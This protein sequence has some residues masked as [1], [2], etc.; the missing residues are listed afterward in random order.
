MQRTLTIVGFILLFII[1]VVVLSSGVAAGSGSYNI[2]SDPLMAVVLIG[3]LVTVLILTVIV[4]IGLAQGF[5]AL[6]KQVAAPGDPEERPAIERAA[7]TT[8]DNV[9]GRL[10]GALKRVG[11]GDSEPV[12]PYVPAYSYK[13]LPE[14]QESRQFAIGVGLVVLLLLVYVAITQGR[15]LINA[16]NLLTPV[17]WAV[18][19]GSIIVIIGAIGAVGFG[20]SI[21][22]VKTQEEKGKAEKLKEPAWPAEQIPVWEARIRNAPQA[23]KQMTFLDMSL[24]GL[25]LVL[26]AIV[27]G[28]IGVWVVPGI[29]HVVQVDAVLN[30]PPPTAVA[31]V[32]GGSAVPAELQAEFDKLPAGD[33]AAGEALYNAGKPE[34]GATACR[35]CHVDTAVGPAMP[36]EP[37][38]ATRAAT[39]KPGFPPEVYI[40]ESITN[41]NAFLAPSFQ[42]DLMPQ[43]FS[44]TLSEQDIA[45]L[46]AYVMTLK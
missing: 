7:L 41:P 44:E 16:A 40:Y 26:V 6:S 20:L 29:I 33:A 8:L 11:Y 37:P 13:A 4:G 46:I 38:I 25:N 23:I 30:P 36:G 5:A 17:Q 27:L 2:P 15:N 31:V 3:A 39:R 22:F 19:V 35:T 42:P 1:G 14:D 32:P 18:G 45:D 12:K 10:E 28:I 43:N 34:A 21:W 9:S 24:I